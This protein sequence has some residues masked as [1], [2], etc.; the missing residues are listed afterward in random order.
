KPNATFG[1]RTANF[2]FVVNGE[3]QP[4][5]FRI[6]QEANVPYITI[7]DGDKGIAVP[8]VGGPLSVKLQTNV[9]WTYTLSD[10]SWITSVAQNTNSLEHEDEKNTGPE[11]STTLTVSSSANGLSQEVVLV[12]SAGNVILEE[13]FGWLTYVYNISYTT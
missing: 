4:V 8:A 7:V 6:E 12:Q 11:R 9:E 13:N 1:S 3:E 10:E 5:L 2:A